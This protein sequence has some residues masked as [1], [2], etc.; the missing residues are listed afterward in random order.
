MPTDVI[1]NELG[2]ASVSFAR[3]A[4]LS[5]GVSNGVETKSSIATGGVLGTDSSV[6]VSTN[7]LVSDRT[8]VPS[9][10]TVTLRANTPASVN[11]GANSSDPVPSPLSSNAANARSVAF[12]LNDNVSDKS[13]SVADIVK[14]SVAPSLT[15]CADIAARTGA[16][17]ASFTVSMNSV[18]LDRM[19]VPSSVT[20]TLRANT[21]ASVNPGVNSS[22]PVPSPL[23]ANAPNGRS[24]AF[25]LNDNV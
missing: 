19:G 7:S 3:T 22:D 2:S 5:S 25:V 23:S 15:F 6:T 16:P 9:S 24:V 10:D 4:M 8:G 21:P 17:L 13:G 20:V 12:V 18:V 14:L 11:P 1:V